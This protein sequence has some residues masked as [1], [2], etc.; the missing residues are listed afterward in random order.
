MQTNFGALQ[1]HQKRAWGHESYRVFR[2]QFFWLKLLGKGESGVVERVSEIKK[3]DK[4]TASAMLRLVA[5]LQGGGIVGDNKVE[6]RESALESYWQ[7]IQIDR[8]RKGVRN[9]GILSEQ[10]SVIDFRMEAKDKLGQWM[11]ETIDELMFLTASGISYD[12][13]C[14]GS[15]RLIPNGEDALSTLLFHN[16]VS[17]PSANRHFRWTGTALTTGNTG[18]IVNTDIPNYKM[19][20]DLMAEAQTRKVKPIKSGGKEYRIL[21][22]HPKAFAYL[23]KD[24]DFRD[25]L[26]NAADRGMNNPIFTGAAVTY[27]G[28]VIH[29]HNKVFNTLRAASGSKWGN[30]GAVN[31]TRTL[32]LGAQSLALADIETPKWEED[33]FDYKNQQ[34]IEISKIFGILKPKFKA[35]YEGTVEDF[36]VIACDHFI[37]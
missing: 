3:T 4:G 5:D 23:K 14:D 2:D 24:P 31:G 17:A 21:L 18:A 13:N 9:K 11:A 32:L 29:T 30:S 7:E 28:A 33:T 34:G 16:D 36:G 35:P 15:T 37:A 20:V 1:P 26:I 8:L 27:D 25:A 12:L 19:I 22:M 6:D 10:K